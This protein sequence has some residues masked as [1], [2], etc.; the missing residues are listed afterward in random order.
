MMQPMQIPLT[1]KEE[2]VQEAFI[3]AIFVA[4]RKTEEPLV[5]SLAGLVGA[6][7]SSVA[8]ELSKYLGAT[9]LFGDDIRVALRK[10]KLG[11]ANAS[12]IR[13][14]VI[15]TIIDKGGVAIVDADTVE[16][17]RREEMKQ[18]A[19][20]LGVRH[21]FIR[22]YADPDVMV[23]RMISASHKNSL[24][25]FFGGALSRWNGKQSLKGAIVKIREMWRRTP[26]H[27]S[28]NSENGG[29]WIFKSMSF[30]IFAAIDTTDER[31][32]KRDVAMLAGKLLKTKSL[33]VS[34]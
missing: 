31:K 26:H 29:Q 18:L 22:V 33:V 3:K 25:D 24:D 12:L 1:R 15:R 2:A 34:E 8:E 28:W 14:N 11:F 6:G 19:R 9:I 32:W 10:Q 21:F 13:S 17:Q 5:I 16:A 30:P 7:K 23:G 4:K 27:Y 20:R